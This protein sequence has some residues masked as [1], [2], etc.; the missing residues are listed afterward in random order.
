M[1]N[2]S[3][4]RY[5]ILQPLAQAMARQWERYG[6]IQLHF[7]CTHNSRRSQLAQA[8]GH[9][10]A[11]DLQLPITSYS[12]GVEVTACHPN[13]LA[14]LLRAGFV[15]VK[16]ETTTQP[17]YWVQWKNGAPLPLYSK[18]FDDPVNPSHQFIAA[19]TCAEADEHCPFIPG[20][21]QRL[22]LGY[23]DPKA[24]D[25]TPEAVAAYD[26]TSAHIKQELTALFQLTQRIHETTQLR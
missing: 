5:D 12:G 16:T 22:P 20:A 15:L 1:H 21:E 8:W 14:A 4:V 24:W 26:R 2:H 13:T 11:A 18:L 7:I 9:A 6:H 25:A 3:A 19:M 23:T 17:T 10:L